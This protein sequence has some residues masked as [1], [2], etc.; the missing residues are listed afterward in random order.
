[1]GDFVRGS[2]VT[3]IGAVNMDITDA[4]NIELWIDTFNETYKK[5]RN[6]FSFVSYADGRTLVGYQLTQEESLSCCEDYI[7]IQL[8]WTDSSGYV[9][10]TKRK[11]LAVD[12]A[13]WD[14]EMPASPTNDDISFSGYYTNNYGDQIGRI[15]EYDISAMIAREG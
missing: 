3:L 1:M 12:S 8:R 6:N 4:Q 5:N 7:A 14:I 2:T 15:T 11:L 9:Y 13:E 10:G